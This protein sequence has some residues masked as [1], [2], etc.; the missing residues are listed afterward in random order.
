MHKALSLSDRAEGRLVSSGLPERLVDWALEDSMFTDGR[1]DHLLWL[2]NAPI[3]EIKSWVEAGM[4]AA[5]LP[6]NLPTLTC[7]RCGHTWIPR[8]PRKPGVCSKCKSPY[9]DKPRRSAKPA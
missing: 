2:I 4:Y 6:I 8:Q 3:E 9:W 1:N 5:E 7:R